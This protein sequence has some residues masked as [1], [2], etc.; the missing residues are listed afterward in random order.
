MQTIQF[1]ELLK[2][3]YS[4]EK[5]Q[6]LLPALRQ[7]WV[8]YSGLQEPGALEK[9]LDA[10]GDKELPMHPGILALAAI[11]PELVKKNYPQ[12]RPVPAL[13]ERWM[14]GL[15]AFKQEPHPVESL[16]ENVD[17]ALTLVE[18]RKILPNWEKLFREIFNTKK[19]PFVFQ[20]WKTAF[21]I[22][23]QIIDDPENFYAEL[24]NPDSSGYQLQLWLYCNLCDSR[25]EN[26]KLN[27]ISNGIRVLDAKDQVEAIR[28]LTK[29]TGNQFAQQVAKNLVNEF[30]SLDESLR[31]IGEKSIGSAED[32]N[33]IDSQFYRGLIC[34]AAGENSLGLQWIHSAKATLANYQA[35][36]MV[37]EV[38]LLNQMGKKEEA[39]SLALELANDSNY[40]KRLS[41][42]LTLALEDVPSIG[43][44]KLMET[45]K[46]PIAELIEAK[47]IHEAGN[48]ALALVAA[49]NAYDKIVHSTE[50]EES[51]FD[52][53]LAMNWNEEKLFSCLHE[54]GQDQ[55]AKDVATKIIRQNAS[56]VKML[57]NAGLLYQ[58]NG[59]LENAL[60]SYQTLE[61]ACPEDM[62]VKRLKALCLEA[63]K[64]PQQAYATWKTIVENSGQ[65][66]E[67]DLIHLAENALNAKLL[68]ETIDAAQKIPSES[69]NIGKAQALIGTAYHAQGNQVLAAQYLGQAI[70]NSI[71]DPAPW[72]ILS[73]IYT[74]NQ[75]EMKAI[76]TLR[77]AKA[78]FPE[79]IEIS[80]KLAKGLENQGEVS[81]AMSVISNI[82][83]EHPEHIE[84]Q[85]LNVKVMKALHLEEV[86][87]QIEN[88]VKLYP[89]N[90]EVLYLA[91]ESLVKKGK[92]FEAIPFLQK[93]Y[94]VD[95]TNLDLQATLADALAGED[96]RG[97]VQIRDPKTEKS[98]KELLTGVLAQEPEH[99]AAS[100]IQAEIALRE[101]KPDEA[102][103]LLNRLEMG[104][105]TIPADWYWRIQA[106]I[107]RAAAATGKFEIALASIQEAIDNQPALIGLRKV[108]AEIYQAAG[109]I[110]DALE[111]ANKVLNLAPDLVENVLWFVSFVQGLGKTSE[112]EK[113]LGESI[114]KFP[115]EKRYSIGLARLFADEGR[116]NEAVNL[117]GNVDQ[118][119][120]EV[121]DTDLLRN[122]A[123]IY[124]R[125]GISS[126]VEKCLV[127]RFEQTTE[128]I[129]SGIELAGFYAG[130][131]ETNKALDLLNEL[132]KRVHEYNKPAY[133]AAAMMFQEG[134]FS[135]AK[136]YL[137]AVTGD[138]PESIPYEFVPEYWNHYLQEKNP[139]AI[140][141]AEVSYAAG[142]FTEAV[143]YSQQILDTEPANENALMINCMAKRALGRY[144][145]LI[146]TNAILEN[147]NKSE[148]LIG[149]CAF[150]ILENGSTVFPTLLTEKLQKLGED[151]PMVNAINAIM[152]A[153]QSNIIEGEV[154]FGECKSTINEGSVAPR[155]ESILLYQLIACAAEKLQRL[156]IAVKFSRDLWK[157][158]S[159]NIDLA[160][161]Y[162]RVAAEAKETFS[163][164]NKLNLL[165]HKASEEQLK[166]AASEISEVEKNLGGVN[167]ETVQRWI[168]RAR[169]ALNPTQA[170]LKALALIPPQPDDAA[171]M[172]IALHQNGQDNTAIQVARK[173][174]SDPSVMRVLAICVMEKDP[175][176]AIR[177]ME[178][179]L[180][181][182]EA[183]PLGWML[184]SSMEEFA[185]EKLAAISSCENALSYWPEET[186]WHVKAADLWMAAGDLGNARLHLQTANEQEPDDT[187]IMVKLGEVCSQLGDHEKAISILESATRLETNQ[188]K[189]WEALA[190]SYYRAGDAV[191]AEKAALK[192]SEV[193]PFSIKPSLLAGKVEFERG[194]YNKALEYARKAISKN[195]KNSS[196]ITF[197]ANIL[198]KKGEKTQALA[199]L[200]KAASCEDATI[201][202]MIRHA[203]LVKEIKGAADSKAIF[204]ELVQRYPENLELLRLLIESQNE[205]GEKSKAEATARLSLKIQP[206]QPD[207][208]LSLGKIKLNN[209]DLDQAVYHFSQAI[210]QDGSLVEAYIELSRA[211]QKQRNIHQ[212][213]EILQQGMRMNPR[214]SQ[215]YLA[216]AGLL[217][218][219]KDYQGA[220][221]MLRKAA[222]IEPDD[223]NIKRQLGAVIA[224]NLVHNS[225]QASSHL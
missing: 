69:K 177:I 206:N 48:S 79:S 202:T 105:K 27:S 84:A 80:Y 52:Q 117:V 146:P 86:D 112:A 75:D 215:I 162:L 187:D 109:R 58:K 51:C 173:F 208:H 214:S 2:Q 175:A 121:E 149:L 9:A 131:G 19:V 153:N 45:Q 137:N 38:S 136:E 11:Y 179:S 47:S 92:R 10:F 36:L 68:D 25:T 55:S 135:E 166:E 111:A 127:K 216:A 155:A 147:A 89:N 152:A 78:A 188:G 210:T 211:Y 134:R 33:E 28:F 150:Q 204:E 30:I 172:M 23:S 184:K 198:M 167:L 24:L 142:D 183:Q 101:M 17:L 8:I 144:N 82:V 56:N 213:L 145:E 123:S 212:A 171:A 60:D 71:T 158:Q 49:A 67:D 35:G 178:R 218:E 54:I 199:A 13:L 46:S 59:D 57:M 85:L 97:C 209:G 168:A 138:E 119:V 160:L 3:N 7:D 205:C 50:N 219:S 6:I 72:I 224:L 107:A 140:L 185:G 53:Q 102:Y 133:L 200:E 14:V 76:E 31:K 98:A 106:G 164:S 15:E 193:D 217:R 222:E 115:A 125:S 151:H 207:L 29:Y 95:H 180:Q 197:L 181:M 99:P 87:Q 139:K 73:E 37:T 22:C 21:V 143:T 34:Q 61:I 194:D 118:L 63:V 18:K 221:K 83:K 96:Y 94:A 132:S 16:L 108:L 44:Q 128:N 120:E 186:H 195:E 161:Q 12:T 39:R 130:L 1:F 116:N 100:V 91:G 189:I 191:N 182:M 88:L 40:G 32:L 201:E 174:E 64:E 225:Q 26:E 129:E 165:I 159:Q 41:N 170:N 196:A 154:A 66:E 190:D 110:N 156:D 113:V 122:A 148:Y 176:E 43:D 103:D 104:E 90:T 114:Q 65:V 42:E 81:E 223:L 169:L 74:G 20:I 124:L 77:A 192:A 4:I 220:E 141:G 93:A 126:A 203:Q 70:E 62:N 5:L 157:V 163:I